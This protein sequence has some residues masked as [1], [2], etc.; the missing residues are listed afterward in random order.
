MVQVLQKRILVERTYPLGDSRL[1]ADFSNVYLGMV[2]LAHA[3]FSGANVT[4]ASFVLANLS[5]TV[6]PQEYSRADRPYARTT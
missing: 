6:I 2:N 5:G 4:G 1:I 3:D